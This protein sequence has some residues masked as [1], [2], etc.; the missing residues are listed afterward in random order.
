MRT[1]ETLK[2]GDAG[3]F[4][5]TIT[6]HDVFAFADASGDFNPLH[7]DEE[8]ARR[9]AFGRRIAHGILTAGIIS[10]VLGSEIPGLGTIFVQLEIRFLKPVFIGDTVTARAVVMEIMN[11]KRVRLLV[12]C[13]NQSGEDV[14]IGNAV[15][16]PPK[17]TVVQTG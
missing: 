14:A 7:I 12:S 10:T 13:T 15:V 11:P 1:R 9:S 3:S 2:V 8:Y 5:K 6:E 4:S 17:A 16:V